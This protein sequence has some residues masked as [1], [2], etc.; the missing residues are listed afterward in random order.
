MVR[1]RYLYSICQKGAFDN[2]Q[3]PV[4]VTIPEQLAASYGLYIWP[5]SPVLAWYLWLN[6]VG[7][8]SYLVGY[9]SEINY[10]AQRYCSRLISKVLQYIMKISY[11]RK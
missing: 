11:R 10:P 6:Q 5:S 2:V 4:E 3:A 9:G 8:L 1:H 7:F